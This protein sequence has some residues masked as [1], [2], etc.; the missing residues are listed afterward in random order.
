MYVL[1]KLDASDSLFVKLEGL[2]G[3]RGEVEIEPYHP[4]VWNRIDKINESTCEVVTR[5]K[6]HLLQQCRGSVW[7]EGCT[8]SVVGTD[9]DVVS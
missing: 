2:V 3:R 8:P 9:D 1:V 5:S 7:V 6:S 4:T